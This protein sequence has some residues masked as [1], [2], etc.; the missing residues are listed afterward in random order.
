MAIE[1][2]LWFC[3]E[4]A[5]QVSEKGIGLSIERKSGETI[6]L[7]RTDS[8][9][10]REHFYAPGDPQIAC[11]RL[12]FYKYADNPPVLIFVELKG[13][14]LPHALEQLKQ[15]IGVVKPRVEQAV[16][17]SS[18]YLA[19]VVS[20]GASP[21][22]RASKQRDFEAK[23]QV[24]LRVQSTDRGKKAVDLRAVLRKID[25]LAPFVAD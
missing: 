5:T 14:N 3:L 15:T 17:K 22:T 19:L 2:L 13:A 7:F 11:D 20:D 24:D 23:T 6:L 16:R 10:F 9:E 1:P 18:K 12:F 8:K 21:T 25:A 4:H